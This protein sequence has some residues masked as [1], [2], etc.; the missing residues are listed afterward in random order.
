[1]SHNSDSRSK[2]R[3][4]VRK[5][6]LHLSTWS[7]ILWE[8]FVA[9]RH[10]INQKNSLKISA[11]VS[12]MCVKS[13]QKTVVASE[14]A[15]S[16][17]PKLKAAFCWFS[18]SLHD[19]RKASKWKK[20]FPVPTQKTSMMKIEIGNRWRVLLPYCSLNESS[21][22]MWYIT[23]SR[24]TFYG[25]PLTLLFEVESSAGTLLMCAL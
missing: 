6:N 5:S 2:Q 1:M 11:G 15:V 23:D 18:H 22:E 10:A 19:W 7:F 16:K 13:T 3:K 8:M 12:L 20:F 17:V 9:L 21:F 24:T 25:F 4:K 14:M